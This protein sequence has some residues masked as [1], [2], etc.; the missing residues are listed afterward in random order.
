M[1]LTPLCLFNALL[2]VAIAIAFAWIVRQN[3]DGD[4]RVMMAFRFFV[5]LVAVPYLLKAAERLAGDPPTPID[6]VR[7]FGLLGVLV[8]FIVYRRH[9]LGRW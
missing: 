1:T 5:V 9:R 8:A 7:D 4:N 3:F 2:C 6:S